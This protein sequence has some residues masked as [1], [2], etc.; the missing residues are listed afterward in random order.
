[1]AELETSK[2][3]V[4]NK[5]WANGFSCYAL[6]HNYSITLLRNTSKQVPKTLLKKER[7]REIEKDYPVEERAQFSRVWGWI[8]GCQRDVETREG[9]GI[10]RKKP[11]FFSR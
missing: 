8:C 7:G 9:E 1:M 11:K 4:G 10:V 6:I 5:A 2:T 3:H